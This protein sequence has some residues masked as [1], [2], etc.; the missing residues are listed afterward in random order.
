[1]IKLQNSKQCLT[2]PRFEEDTRQSLL[3][4]RERYEKVVLIY[5]EVQFKVSEDVWEQTYRAKMVDVETK[6]SD[7]ET[8]KAKVFAV[9]QIA[10]EE[11][12]SIAVPRTGEAGAAGGTS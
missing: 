1:M 3:V 9:A 8:K 11:H 10:V 6:K 12:E 4:V 2:S 7:S 5:D